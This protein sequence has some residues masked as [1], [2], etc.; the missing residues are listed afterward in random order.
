MTQDVNLTNHFLIAMPTLADPH[1]FHSVTYICEHSSKGAMGIVINRT[2]ELSLS[3]L[4]EH[5]EIGHTPLQA[6]S[7]PLF[8]GGPVEAERGFVLHEFDRRWDSTMK[9]SENLAI[10]TSRDII[11][12]IANSEGPQ[13]HLIALGYAGWHEGQL[14]QEIADNAWLCGPADDKILFDTP[15]SQRWEAAAGKIGVDLKLLSTTSGHA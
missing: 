13:R 11:E 5:M 1:F 3:D 15:I 10:T 4:F 7:M 2:V 8:N 6:E 9:I 14:E 12:A